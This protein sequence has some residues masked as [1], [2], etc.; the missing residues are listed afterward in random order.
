MDGTGRR[1]TSELR[2]ELSLESQGVY[3]VLED[4]HV[5]GFYVKIDLI[6]KKKGQREEY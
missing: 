1:E 5:K 4:R 3:T 2:S 6:R